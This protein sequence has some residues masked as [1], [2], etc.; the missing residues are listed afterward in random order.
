MRRARDAFLLAAAA[1]I[2]AGTVRAET[3]AFTLDPAHTR[4][5]WETRHF[6]TST[7][8]GRFDRVEGSVRIDR[9]DRGERHGDVSISIAT[10]SVSSGVPALDSVLRGSDFLAATAHPTAFFVASELRFDGERLAEVRGEFTLRGVSRPLALRTLNFGCRTDARLQRE[11]CG[12]DF[13]GE[14]KRSEFGSSLGLPFVSDR[15]RLVISVEGVR[16]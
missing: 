5:H 4:V 11:V 3:L 7:Q 12:G 13:E 15:V 6:G 14:L 10:G 8:R 2:A 1:L 16:Q 9:S